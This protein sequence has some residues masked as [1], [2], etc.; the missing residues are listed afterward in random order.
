MDFVVILN[1]ML[2]LLLMMIIGYV[3]MRLKMLGD[4][5]NAVLSKVVLNITLPAQII[6]SFSLDG[7]AISN[8]EL[9]RVFLFSCAV[10]A[11]Y[12]VLAWLYVRLMRLPREDW[13]TYQYMIIFGNVG[14]MGFPVITAIF[15]AN[16]LVY[17]VILNIV[18]NLLVFSWGIKL[19]TAGQGGSRF[20]WRKL[21]NP[22]LIATVLALIL[23]FLHIELPSVLNSAL[24][25]L[26]DATTPMAML[27]L[28]SSIAAMPLK[29]LFEEW[30]VYIF[31]VLKLLVIPLLVFL[32]LRPFLA[33][34]DVLGQILVVLSAVPVATNATML[35]IEYGGNIKLV[36]QGIFFTTILSVITIPILVFLLF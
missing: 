6:T 30:R 1:Q 18:F 31:V 27:I 11:F 8:A 2:T 4:N 14:F 17:A 29:E 9:G 21:V 25:T 22:A 24:L 32:A 15:G 33:A 36:S 34:D 20:D 5:V 12:G 35:S 23:F 16:R 13:G 7:A 10:Y 28:G 19:I 3:M 26:G